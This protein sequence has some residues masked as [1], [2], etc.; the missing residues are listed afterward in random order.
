MKHRLYGKACNQ[1]QPRNIYWTRILSWVFF[2]KFIMIL[3][4]LKRE[5]IIIIIRG[6]TVP[7]LPY[8]Y[9]IIAK[10]NLVSEYQED[11]FGVAPNK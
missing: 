1:Y 2:S 10:V 11:C 8:W 4:V 5:F 6:A 7:D 3:I 9:P